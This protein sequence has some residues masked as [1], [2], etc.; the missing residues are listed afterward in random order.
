MIPFRTLALTG[1]TCAALVVLG[2]SNAA[3]A[4]P[5]NGGAVFSVSK[6]C[7]ALG[8][9]IPAT[10][11]GFIPGSTVTLTAAATDRY[12]GPPNPSRSIQPASVTVNAHGSFSGHLTAFTGS[13]STKKWQYAAIT[14]FA[15]ASGTSL[16]PTHA[17]TGY[18]SLVIASPKICK[19][20]NHPPKR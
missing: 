1:A 8:K 17:F 2:L 3:W 20:L 15:T 9:S 16:M 11:S 14:V 18:D 19:T 7:V 4:P 13:P 5:V 6:P 10:G 12:T